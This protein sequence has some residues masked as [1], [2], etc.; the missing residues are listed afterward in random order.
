MSINTFEDQNTGEAV[1]KLGREFGFNSRLE[2][3]E[4]YSKFEPYKNFKLDFEPV[5]KIDSSTFGMLLLMRE[6]AKG[7]DSTITITGC[8]NKVADSLELNILSGLFE[9][10]P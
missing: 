2:F 6:Y 4:A 10:R 7:I 9:I 3:S 8:N 5:E 1:I